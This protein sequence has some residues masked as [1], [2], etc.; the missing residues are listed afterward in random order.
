MASLSNRLFANKRFEFSSKAF[1][2]DKFAVVNMEGFEAISQPFRFT[3][4]LVSDDASINFDKM[5][6]NPATFS[7][8]APDGASHTPYHG[9]LAEFDQLH[10]ADGYVFYRAVLVPRLWRLSLY[11]ISEVY[12]SEQSIPTTLET[13]LKNGRL[14]SADYELKLMGTYRPRSFVCQ[15]QEPHLDF[16]SRWMEKEGM[17]YY[18]DHTGDADKLIVADNRTMHDAQATRINYR[19][20]DQLDTGSS[21][22]SVQD[23]VCRQRPL[24]HQVVLQDF[25]HRKASLTLKAEA[26]VSDSGIGEVMLY[27]ENFRDLEEGNRYAKLRA[28]E[29]ICG[30]KV[31]SGESTAVG[32]RSGYFAELSRH[33]R[34][35]FNGKYL[36]TEIHHQGSQAGALLTGIQNQFSES[37]ANAETSYHN[38][39]RA[40]PAAVQ[41]RA[42]RVTAKPRVAGT[43]SATI[44]SEGSGEYAELDAYGQYKV[45]LPFDRT[46]KN[47]N[48]GSARVRMAT[49][50]SG[51]DHGMHFPL[52][53]DAEVLL[54]FIDGDPDQPVILGAVPNSDNANIVTQSN[55][56]ENRISTAGGNHLLMDDSKGKE[57]MWLHSPASNTTIGIGATTPDNDVSL[58]TSTSGNSNSLTVGSATAIFSGIKNSLTTS[59]ENSISASMV[60]KYAIGASVGCSWGYDLAWKRG[61]NATIDDSDTI[62]LKTMAKTLGSETVWIAG[63]QY[64]VPRLAVQALKDTVISAAALGVAVNAVLGIGAAGEIA[65]TK[66]QGK[67]WGF[68]QNNGAIYQKV[69]GGIGGG[70]AAA[71]AILLKLAAK[72][73]FAHSGQEDRYASNIKVNDTHIDMDYCSATG[74]HSK[75]TLESDHI[76]LCVDTLLPGS[77]SKL[78][79]K[80]KTINLSANGLPS[81]TSELK[82]SAHNAE[83][84]T[85][86]PAGK[87][88]MKHPSSAEMELSSL[89]GIMQFNGNG[90]ETSPS[91]VEARF[92]R[93][94]MN[95]SVDSAKLVGG[96]GASELDLSA[97]SATLTN[98]GAT[99]SLRGGIARV[100]AQLI[101]LA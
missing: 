49:P 92:E 84:S 91:D 63:G 87:V 2:D 94:F 29:I 47:A 15:Y 78:D 11:R 25:N 19:P 5:L 62:S 85:Q 7:I 14:T 12:L 6:E 10:R 34:E 36:I 60:N 76:G 56:H 66:N 26:I 68:S 58:W 80:S 83:L 88:V 93:N 24:P 9:V 75:L 42:E 27:G 48:K 39:F 45:Q 44:D 32:L 57:A 21:P 96:A 1:G 72:S 101:Q 79:M 8:F 52:H 54:S 99:L 67:I 38:S 16:L 89:G 97:G 50:Y 13:V 82:L 51:S 81:L 23:F 30:G 46:A 95:L 69:Q 100:N 61:I 90:I 71:I 17:Y 18:F 41:F 55:P 59:L 43:M 73:I 4:T 3:L 40:I 70:T 37:G 86:N 98:A 35:D 64:T 77:E 20:G 22:D 31:F 74:E 28:E 65:A 33:Y 53:K